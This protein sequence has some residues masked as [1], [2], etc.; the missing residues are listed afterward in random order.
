VS[1]IID[2]GENLPARNLENAIEFFCKIKYKAVDFS[3][4]E[5]AVTGH[6]GTPAISGSKTQ[7]VL[8]IS[9]VI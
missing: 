3:A 2:E 1:G 4:R 8:R 7:P 5:A 6:P 9:I